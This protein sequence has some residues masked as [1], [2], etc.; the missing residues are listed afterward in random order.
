MS[1]ARVLSRV[2]VPALRLLLVVALL[3]VAAPA[4]AVKIMSW[5]VLNYPGASGPSRDD[6]LRAVISAVDPDIVVMQE[7]QNSAGAATM[8]TNVFDV[9]GPGQW[10]QATFTNGNDSDNAL[11]FRTGEFVE[12]E[13]GEVNTFPRETDWWRLR[14]ATSAVTS[15]GFVIYSTHL[16]ASQGSDNVEQRR[17]AA[18]A[19]RDDMILRW[20]AGQPV[21]VMGDFNLYTSSEPAWGAL[22]GNP[23]EPAQLYDPIDE[24]GSWNN[25]AVFAAVHTQSTRSVTQSDGGATGGMDSRFDFILVDADLQDTEGWDF[26]AG[27]YDAFGQDGQHFNSSI[28]AAPTNA[29]VGQDL[30]NNLFAASDHLPVVLELQEPAQLQFLP[31]VFAIGPVLEGESVIESLQLRNTALAPVDE[32]DFEVVATEPGVLLGGDT[33]GE[34]EAGEI[35]NV[36][37]A[38]DTATPRV[39]TGGLQLTTDD[40]GRSDVLVPFEGAVVRPAVPSLGD[41]SVVESTTIALSDAEATTEEM[42]YTVANVGADSVQAGVYVSGTQIGGTDAARFS[43]LDPATYFVRDTPLDRRVEVDLNGLDAGTTIEATV[44]LTTQDDFLVQGASPRATLVVTLQAT[45]AGGATSAPPVI[46]ATTLHPPVPSPFNPRTEVRFDL[47][48]AGTVTLEVLDVR[49]RR[50]RTLIEGRLDAGRHAPVWDGTDDG[51]RAAASGVYL[52]RLRTTDGN[53]VRRAVL[54]R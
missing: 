3:L 11:Y 4:S 7:I 33:A 8:K 25:N 12:V 34:L 6:D 49:G 39:F 28:N 15:T 54:V 38:V 20:D 10:T 47:A 24:A 17:I 2:D 18:R 50:V 14:S 35:A 37:V 46:S 23:I 40:P 53:Q 36:N 48:R 16:K 5:N 19:I 43:L 41:T 30:A 22:T 21:M 29:A 51:G 31:E 13:F 32:L 44:T 27:T 9:I 52:F 26:L 1:P 42:S 45:V